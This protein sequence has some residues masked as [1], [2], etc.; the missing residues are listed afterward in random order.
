MDPQI[1]K[2]MVNKVLIYPFIKI[3]SGD[4]LFGDPVEYD[5]IV[6]PKV[7]DSVNEFGEHQTYN[8]KVLIDGIADGLITT[9]DEIELTGV[10]RVPIRIVASYNSLKPGKQLI[11]VYC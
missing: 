4:K 7:G 3:A 8:N 5:C 1:R 11:E 6:I 2:R 10:G 9:K